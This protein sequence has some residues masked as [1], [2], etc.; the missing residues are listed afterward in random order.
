MSKT[1]TEREKQREITKL[2]PF[3]PTILTRGTRKAAT[4]SYIRD[5]NKLYGHF[6]TEKFIVYILL[7]PF[8]DRKCLE[9]KKGGKQRAREKR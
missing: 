1:E 9:S 6:A 7:R 4:V 3:G 8:C 5:Y 2:S